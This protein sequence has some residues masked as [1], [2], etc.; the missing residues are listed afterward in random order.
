MIELTKSEAKGIA[1][2][3]EW[4][5]SALLPSTQILLNQSLALATTIKRVLENEFTC[6]IYMSVTAEISDMDMTTP[7][8]KRMPL[9]ICVYLNIEVVEHPEFSI[10]MEMADASLDALIRGIRQADSPH[11]MF[12]MEEHEPKDMEELTEEQEGYIF[13]ISQTIRKALRRI[14]RQVDEGELD[15][16]QDDYHDR[17]AEE[18]EEFSS[19]VSRL[20]EAA[21]EDEDDIV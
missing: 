20:Y 15:M 13:Y 7:E 14:K 10:H 4:C 21:H 19:M 18:E 8:M 6:I 2:R 9:A 16:F 12:I 11:H 5:C 17:R 1:Q 3:E